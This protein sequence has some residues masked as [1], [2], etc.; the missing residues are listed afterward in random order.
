MS[1]KIKQKL[2][3]YESDHLRVGLSPYMLK[4]FMKEN[5]QKNKKNSKNFIPYSLY[6]YV[7]LR[8]A[9]IRFGNMF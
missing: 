7:K 3:S 1:V 9:T 6:G 5:Q 4:T 2:R 8:S